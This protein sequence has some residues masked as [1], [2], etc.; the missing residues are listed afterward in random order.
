MSKPGASIDDREA[1]SDE[2]AY[3]EIFDALRTYVAAPPADAEALWG[4]MA[5]SILIANV[6]D[7]LRNNGFLRV[8]R[9]QWRIASA[10]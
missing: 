5:F 7:H 8:D 3:T 9:R 4:R 10:F 6:D 2:H 1:E